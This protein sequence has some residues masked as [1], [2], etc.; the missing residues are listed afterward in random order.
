MDIKFQCSN[1]GCKDFKLPSDLNDES[2]VACND[3]GASATY[4]KLREDGIAQ[5][6]E[7]IEGKLRN[8]FKGD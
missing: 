1:C 2:I 8:L 4:G 3:C 5:T 7:L 6:K